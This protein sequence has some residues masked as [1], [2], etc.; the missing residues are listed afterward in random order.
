MGTNVSKTVGNM[1]NEIVSEIDQTS[2]ASATAD[3]SIKT[4]NINLLRSRRS[5]VTNENR[6][7]ASAS[8]ALEAT[9]NA[10]SNA[11]MKATNEQKANIMPGMNVNSSSQDIKNSIRNKINQSCNANSATTLAIAN[12]D[13]TIEDCEDSHIKNI[14]FGNAVANCGVKTVIQTALA[15]ESE[16]ET[17]QETTGL[18]EGIIGDQSNIFYYIIGGSTLS[19]CMCCCCCIILL[20]MF[21]LMLSS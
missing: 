12:G 15:S 6:C 10:A 5:S 9:V 18:L 17:K 11:F 2:T 14:N 1:T 4:G 16:S 7:G 8:A 20:I 13:I 3:C 19:S 21:A